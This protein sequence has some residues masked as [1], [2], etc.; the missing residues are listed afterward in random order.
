MFAPTSLPTSLPIE[1]DI[2]KEDLVLSCERGLV[3]PL[4]I[5]PLPLPTTS[6]LDDDDSL[7]V[8]VASLFAPIEVSHLL[9]I[10]DNDAHAS[11]EM[12]DETGDETEDDA[13]VTS[14]LGDTGDI[15]GD[16]EDAGDDEDSED[17][18][19]NASEEMEDETEDETEDDEDD[20]ED[21]DD[22]EDSEDAGDEEDS[23]DFESFH[24][25]TNLRLGTVSKST[26]E[27][28]CSKFK[29]KRRRYSTD[30]Y[31]FQFVH[32]GAVKI[33]QKGL[34]MI[35]DTLL[36]LEKEDS[37]STGLGTVLG[38]RVN[39]EQGQEPLLK[40]RK[41]ATQRTQNNLEPYIQR[42]RTILEKSDTNMHKLSMCN[43][44]LYECLDEKKVEPEQ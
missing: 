12:E 32:N 1:W 13:D 16:V 10:T 40:K 42:L 3:T 27:G 15:E 25:A 30:R 38:K 36:R 6:L 23:E 39:T 8:D 11:E 33:L 2:N 44:V 20:E 22:E 18:D 4:P 24:D 29:L 7:F 35:L 28:L 9:A 37:C 21:A 43:T 19:A 41:P 34:K 17:F 26:F 14:D 31:M 5:S